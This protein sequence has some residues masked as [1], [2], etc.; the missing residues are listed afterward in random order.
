MTTTTNRERRRRK[1]RKRKHAH[2]RSSNLLRSY[3]VVCSSKHFCLKLD[4]WFNY[5]NKKMYT[6]DKNSNSSR[7]GGRKKRCC[8]M[9]R[10]CKNTT[11]EWTMLERLIA[12]NR[13]ITGR[14]EKINKKNRVEKNKY[15]IAC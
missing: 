3:T 10:V 2:A 14:D 9:N 12:C 4:N 15:V 1:K 5:G 13:Q 11:I 8:N 6:E 7:N